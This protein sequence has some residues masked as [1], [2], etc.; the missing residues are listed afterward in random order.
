M[1]ERATRSARTCR[2]R[3]GGR[4]G[5]DLRTQRDFDD[6]WRFPGHLALFQGRTSMLMTVSAGTNGVKDAHVTG[7][8]NA[9]I[10]DQAS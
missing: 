1:I 5:I 6:F 2:L 7:P 3:L 9:K 4:V 8:S 10:P